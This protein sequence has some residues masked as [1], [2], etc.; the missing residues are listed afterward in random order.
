MSTSSGE[1][2]KPLI[3]I[4]DVS[5][6]FGSSDTTTQ[7][8]RH[9]SLQ[10]FPGDFVI[11]FGPS[12]CGK[13]TLLNILAGYEIPTSGVVHWK[14][15]LLNNYDNKKISS[16]HRRNVGMIFQQYNLIRTLSVL[17]NVMLP[18]FSESIKQSTRVRRAKHL[19]K[20][21]GLEQY[22]LRLPAELSG[23]QQQRIGIVRALI[24][25]PELILA[26]EP[27]GNLDTKSSKEVMEVI[28]KLNAED[29]TTVVMV[30]HNPEQL[31]YASRVVFLRDGR[32]THEKN[33]SITR[34]LQA[35]RAKMSHLSEE[36]AKLLLLFQALARIHPLSNQDFIRL[37]PHLRQVIHGN[38]P[39]REQLIELFH[40]TSKKEGVGL[41]SAISRRLADELAFVAPLFWEATTT[42]SPL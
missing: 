4:N 38:V 25:S 20:M 13:S 31:S 3:T 23:G 2:H 12:G 29:G 14:H 26:D 28:K 9:I 30:T 27:T 21:I 34:Q 39:A 11:L 5:K 10:I 32:I 16:Y 7:V 15:F 37:R 40:R 18:T 19:L 24:N 8:I 33:E 36:A 6:T 1:R 35:L 42:T 17:D 22:M 41:S